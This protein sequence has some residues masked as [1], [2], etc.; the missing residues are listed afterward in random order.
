MV[1]PLELPPLRQRP[2]DLPAL[3]EHFARQVSIQNGWKPVPFTDQAIGALKQYA[4]PGNIRELRNVIERL[5]LLAE[6]EIDAEAVEL[7]LPAP[8][9]PRSD[10]PGITS[11]PDAAAGSGPLAQRVL[12]FERAAV[13]AELERN[14]RH[15]TQ[16]AKALGLE[17]SHLYKKCQQLGIDLQSLHERD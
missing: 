8:Q 2:E 6:E 9:R 14:H 11:A 4:W 7:A 16:T 12:A 5:L 1:F 17:R 13:L 10:Q 3:V 15:I